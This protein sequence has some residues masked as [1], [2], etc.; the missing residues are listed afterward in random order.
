MKRHSLS[1]ALVSVISATLASGAAWAAQQPAPGQPP[2]P[3]QPP[4]PAQLPQLRKVKDDVYV[5]QNANHVVSEIGRFGGN[6]TV[7][8]TP[9]GVVLVDSKNPDM[10]DDIVSKVRSLTPQPIKYVILT[11]NHGDHAGGAEKMKAIGATLIISE[12]DREN[13]VRSRQPGLPQVAYSGSATVFLGGKEIQLTEHRGHTR[14]DTV[15]YLPASKVVIA[16]DLVTTPDAIPGIVNYGDGGNW[17]DWGKTLDE[18][19]KMDFEVL[20][21][22][23]GPNLTKA[24]FIAFRDKIAGIRERFRALNRERKSAEEIGQTLT[25]EFNWGAPGTPAANVIPGMMQELR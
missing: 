11:H 22:G 20:I 13:M 14:G 6:V 24:E 2:A 21:G 12:A 1:L 23:H 3:A 5:I 10:H 9:E 18:I 16:G 25:R 7:V 8:V 17:T 19:A 15:V 4:T